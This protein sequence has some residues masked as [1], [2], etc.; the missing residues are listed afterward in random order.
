MYIGEALPPLI[1]RKEL[2][3]L[4]IMLAAIMATEY[5]D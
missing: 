1:Y 3:C 2:S 4:N 5:L